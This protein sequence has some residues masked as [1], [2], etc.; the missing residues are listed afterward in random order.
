MLLPLLQGQI[1][2]EGRRVA[3]WGARF[4][5]AN[6]GQK[7]AG[8]A[9]NERHGYAWLCKQR[10][11]RHGRAGCHLTQ[12]AA[13][14]S[15]QSISQGVCQLL[16]LR[17]ELRIGMVHSQPLQPSTAVEAAEGRQQRQQ[18][19]RPGH[20]AEWGQLQTVAALR[21]NKLYGLECTTC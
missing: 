1:P 16:A 18:A 9:A 15:P 20:A 17:G 5:M 14:S 10:R 4:G 19:L 6:G 21:G 11:R 7:G 2:N 3:S 12:Q 8:K 13:A